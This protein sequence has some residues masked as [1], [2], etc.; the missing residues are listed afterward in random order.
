[1]VAESATL[2]GL[3]P[4]QSTTPVYAQ[5]LMTL[6]LEQR[7]LPYIVV[8]R[9]TKWIQREAQRVQVWKALDDSYSVGEF[10]V[11][12]LGWVRERLREGRNSVG[13]KLFEVPDYT[14][15]LFVTSRSDAPD[16]IWRDY[17]RRADM[18]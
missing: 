16:E 4:H 2:N 6:R 3:M 12:L 9:L 1:M 18:E 11:Q 14:F 5:L 17:N 7:S 10:R 13:R 15:R 8:A